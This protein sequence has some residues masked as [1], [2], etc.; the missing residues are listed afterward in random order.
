MLSRDGSNKELGS[1]TSGRSFSGFDSPQVGTEEFRKFLSSLEASSEH[2][3]PESHGSHLKSTPPLNSHFLVQASHESREAV[4][5]GS[6][7][8][9]SGNLGSGSQFGFQESSLGKLSDISIEDFK[10]QELR[11]AQK[12]FD[13]LKFSVSDHLKS[14]SL[15]S[16]SSSQFRTWVGTLSPQTGENGRQL[17]AAVGGEIPEKFVLLQHLWPKGFILGSRENQQ[18]VNLTPLDTRNKRGTVNNKSKESSHNRRVEN[19]KVG[20]NRKGIGADIS[21]DGNISQT[22]NK[23][24]A[25]ASVEAKHE[26]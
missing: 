18:L 1:L 5:F 8:L 20:V 11:F 7:N 16:P 14:G 4:N 6:V 24:L 19:R 25:P 10:P 2:S 26:Q 9:D 17:S 3:L 13:D 12:N 15:Q 23:I 21:D 22:T